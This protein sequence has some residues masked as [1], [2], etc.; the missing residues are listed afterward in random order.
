MEN[1]E[2]EEE[3][4]MRKKKKKK[5]KRAN[6]MEPACST[7]LSA[8]TIKAISQSNC[9]EQT[10]SHARLPRLKKNFETVGP[11]FFLSSS[12]P[13]FYSFFFVRLIPSIVFPWPYKEFRF[14]QPDFS[15][16]SF[17]FLFSSYPERICRFV[18]IHPALLETRKLP[19]VALNFFLFPFFFLLLFNISRAAQKM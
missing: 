5:K 12:F 11:F 19:I 1:E 7:Y 15:L 6:V 10:S 8:W 16:S 2:E 3:L 9:W 18:S 17:L 14:L 4:M 13:S